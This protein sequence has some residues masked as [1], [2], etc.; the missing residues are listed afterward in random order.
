MSELFPWHEAVSAELAT[1]VRDDRLAH[2]LLLHGPAGWGK[3]VLAR[4]FARTLL[5]L[6][7]PPA[8]ALRPGEE[9]SDADLL[10]HPDAR[11]VAREPAPSTGR[12]RG[13]ITVDQIRDL[14][15]FLARTASAGGQRVV[16]LERAEELNPNAANALLKSLEEPGPDTHLLLVCDEP[17]RT[18][19][20]IRSRCQARSLAPGTRAEARAWLLAQLGEGEADADGLLELAGGAPLLALELHR[21]GAGALAAMVDAFLVDGDPRDLVEAPGRPDP[22][23]ARRRAGR[24]LEFLY[25]ALARRIRSGRGAPETLPDQRALERVL[26]ARRVLASTANAQP[27]LLLEDLLLPL[28][29]AQ[30]R[31]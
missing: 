2:A 25:R 11:I 9:A 1:R 7:R 10:S 15:A 18:L 4:Q 29:R 19:A 3:R 5:A 26:A 6:P 22:D 13:Q 21:E 8:N 17:S 24:V 27:R 30:R 20:T 16:I 31:A 23:E 14:A 28:A 12:L